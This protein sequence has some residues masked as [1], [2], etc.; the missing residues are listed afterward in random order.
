MF[1]EAA[2]L[3]FSACAEPA[4]YTPP[5]IN[6]TPLAVLVLIDKAVER[7]S[8]GSQGASVMSSRDEATFSRAQVVPVRGASLL[9]GVRTY[10]I[11]DVIEDDGTHIVVAI[12]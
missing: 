7:W 12:K 3:A 11:G 8:L 6:A 4:T 5:G 10:T 1:A 2:E 9:V